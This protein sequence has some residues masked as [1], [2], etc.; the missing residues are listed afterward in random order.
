MLQLGVTGGSGHRW[1]ASPAWA[2]VSVGISYQLLQL[3]CISYAKYT[4]ALAYHIITVGMIAAAYHIAEYARLGTVA[5]MP[6]IGYALD[7]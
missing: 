7:A 5:K 2:G 6:H 4:R 3:H 1:G